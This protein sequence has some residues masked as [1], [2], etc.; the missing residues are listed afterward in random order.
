[1]ILN[2]PARAYPKE[3][4]IAEKFEAM[5]KLGSFEALTLQWERF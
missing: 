2:R 1:M 5:V 3:L 4:V